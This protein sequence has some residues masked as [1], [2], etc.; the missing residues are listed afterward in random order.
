MRGYT[1]G[2]P[3]ERAADARTGH[4]A[5]P[6]RLHLL[7]RRGGRHDVRMGGELLQAHVPS[8]VVQHVQREPG[9]HTGSPHRQRRYSPRCSRCGTTRRRGTRCRSSPSSISFRQSVGNDELLTTA[10]CLP[11]WLQDDWA[12]TSRLTLNLGLRYDADIGVE[13]ERIELLPWMDGERPHDL[14]NFAPRLGFAFQL[15]DR[16]VLHGGYGKL[17]HAA[18]KRWGTSADAERAAHFP[19]VLYDGRADLQQTRSTD[20]SDIRA[21]SGSGVHLGE[22]AGDELFTTRD[23]LGDSGAGRPSPDLLQPPESFGVQRQFLSDFAVEANFV[24]TGGRAEEAVFN[25]NLTLRPRHR[26]QHSVQQHRRASLPYW[27]FVNGEYMQGW[28]QLSCPRDLADQEVQPRLA[29]A[30]NYTFGTLVGFDRR[31]VSNGSSGR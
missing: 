21:G 20:R 27:G 31:S 7:V 18:R 17:L 6:R 3:T 25:Q 13:G 1:V 28:S 30:A 16:T 19:E 22:R 2:A 10:A 4:V 15:D 8:L 24:F 12:L 11:A 23:Q 29:I 9:R 14:D 26:R 5:G